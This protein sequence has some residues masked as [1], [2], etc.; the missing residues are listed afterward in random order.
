MQVS[1]IKM[2]NTDTIDQITL[3]TKYG[4]KIRIQKEIYKFLKLVAS[5]YLVPNH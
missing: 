3:G 2:E 4:R 1:R 5:I